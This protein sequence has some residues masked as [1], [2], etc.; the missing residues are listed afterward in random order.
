MP[1]LQQMVKGLNLPFKLAFE[2]HLRSQ[3]YNT[4]ELWGQIDDS[5]VT[6]I[7]ENEKNFIKKAKEFG[8]SENFFE[9]VRFDFVIDEDLLI[10]LMEVNMSPNL[11]PSA[12]RFEGHALGYEQVTYTALHCVMGIDHKL[13]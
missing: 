13:K 9:L 7:L 6:L 8:N 1:S 3:G 12:D 4:A 11:T 5:I 2:A 10:H